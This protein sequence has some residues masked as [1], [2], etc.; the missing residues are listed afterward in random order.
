MSWACAK[1]FLRRIRGII[2]SEGYANRKFLIYPDSA[3]LDELLDDLLW[4]LARDPELVGTH[5][6][7]G[8]FMVLT[9]PWLPK[10]MGR[11]AIYYHF[12]DNNVTLAGIRME[13]D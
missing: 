11:M 10:D 13:E 12:D 5:I 4:S 2:E 9:D 8:L 1:V 6:R 3:V 7:G